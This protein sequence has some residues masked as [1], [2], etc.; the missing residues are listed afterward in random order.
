MKST[1]FR[2]A[3]DTQKYNHKNAEFVASSKFI[4]LENLYVYNKLRNILISKN[5]ALQILY[6]EIS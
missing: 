3:G 6:H 5:Q 2:R 1:N 4:Y